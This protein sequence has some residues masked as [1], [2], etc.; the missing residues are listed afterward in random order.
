MRAYRF[1]LLLVTCRNKC[2]LHRTKLQLVQTRVASWILFLLA[3]VDTIGSKLRVARVS[4]SPLKMAKQGPSTKWG[5]G[6]G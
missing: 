4:K 1:M 3:M 2:E 6:F 5:L